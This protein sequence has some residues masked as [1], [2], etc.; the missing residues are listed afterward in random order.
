M[1]TNAYRYYKLLTTRPLLMKRKSNMNICRLFHYV[2]ITIFIT[3]TACADSLPASSSSNAWGHTSAEQLQ[4][5]ISQT[6]LQINE[7]T[8]KASEIKETIEFAWN[9]PAFT[10]DSIVAKRETLKQAEIAFIEAQIALQKEVSRLPEIQKLSEESNA[11]SDTIKILQ[12]KNKTLIGLLKKQHNT[13]PS[14][15]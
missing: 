13:R 5:A 3:T 11:L 12:I 2:V 14:S 1:K 7:H 4:D 9:N 15:K 6:T 10:S 8:R